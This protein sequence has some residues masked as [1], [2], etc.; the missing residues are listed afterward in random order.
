MLIQQINW[1]SSG[2]NT[3]SQVINGTW[4]VTSPHMLDMYAAKAWSMVGRS[5]ACDRSVRLLN[6]SVVP[7]QDDPSSHQARLR[8]TDDVLELSASR[9]SSHTNQVCTSRTRSSPTD[10]DLD[11]VLFASTKTTMLAGD[12]GLVWR[13]ALAASN[14]PIRVCAGSFLYALDDAASLKQSHACR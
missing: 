6:F 10:S 4:C 11:R 3:P 9:Y 12:E 5:C 7:T 8:S 2:R 1:R 13:L 14:V